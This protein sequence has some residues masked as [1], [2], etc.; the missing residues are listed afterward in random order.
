MILTLLAL[1]L[2]A[3]ARAQVSCGAEATLCDIRTPPVSPYAYTCCGTG[4][5]C[6]DTNG[7]LATNSTGSCRFSVYAP[8]TP[9]VVPPW[10]TFPRDPTSSCG[11]Q[12]TRCDGTGLG[13]YISVGFYACCQTGMACVDV[14]GVPAINGS[15]QYSVYATPHPTG[16][17]TPPTPPP[18]LSPPVGALSASPTSD[19]A[20]LEPNWMLLGAVF[21]GCVCTLLVA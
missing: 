1:L 13:L 2:V 14:H 11:V 6:V 16:A 21:L 19:G 3:R 9:P 18:T 8:P 10:P 12:G 5:A 17:P 20:P 4:L 7:A 15:C